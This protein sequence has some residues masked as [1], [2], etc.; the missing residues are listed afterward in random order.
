MVLKPWP[1][2]LTYFKPSPKRLLKNGIEAD[3][4]LRDRQ[5]A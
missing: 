1:G 2:V 5:S 3:P 4:P